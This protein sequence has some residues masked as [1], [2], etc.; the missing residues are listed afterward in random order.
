MPTVG[1]DFGFV[2]EGL[3]AGSEAG[4][5]SFGLDE[6]GLTFFSS[7]FAYFFSVICTIG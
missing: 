6:T 7:F 3:L 1:L 2:V 5:T 4:L